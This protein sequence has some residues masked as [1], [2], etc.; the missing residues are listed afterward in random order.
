[1]KLT[2]DEQIHTILLSRDTV[3]LGELVELTGYPEASVSAGIRGLRK[4]RGLAIEKAYSTTP[5][6]RVCW[7]YFITKGGDKK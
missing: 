1:M 3:T 7:H 6:G 5:N 2:R 4:V